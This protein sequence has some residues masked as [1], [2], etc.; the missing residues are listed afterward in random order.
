[1]TMTPAPPDDFGAVRTLS[2]E[3]GADP[4][5]IQ[6]AGGNSSIKTDRAMWIKA[7]GTKLSDATTGDIFVVTD[8]PAMRQ[9]LR[10]G[11]DAADQPGKF[12]L[13]GGNT[14]RPS[15][16]TS[17]HAVF[18]QRI[19]LHT[20]SIHAI[21]HAIR[22][23]CDA[24]L[25]ARLDG[26]AW[27]KVPYAKPGANLARAVSAV[28]TKDI[29]VVVLGNHGLIV[30]GDAADEVRAL[31]TAVHD[32]L[33]LPAAP[34]APPDIAALKSLTEGTAY[35]P[36]DDSALHAL[37]DGPARLAQVTRGSL[38]PDHV[39]F[40]GIA[41]PALSPGEAVA[42]A[43]ARITATGAPPPVW[44]L[45]PQKGVIVR[46]EAGA[47]A[48]VMMRCLADVMVRVPA[49]A[50]LNYLTDEENFELLDWDAEKYRQSLNAP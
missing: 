46:R 5:H 39:I 25:A 42:G 48:T 20:H 6:G 1:M 37:A 33:A 15:I 31:Q 16:E 24:L 40:C 36:A 29:N 19:V 12:L 41:V 28:L 35:T 27:A 26:F 43:E 3:F 49:D 17:L 21:A 18:D 45:V 22:A 38:Y 4:M 11:E 34:A 8:L 23:D 2:A 9:S 32:A 50:K 14:L 10:A 47:A 7:S 44:L 30:A 13:P